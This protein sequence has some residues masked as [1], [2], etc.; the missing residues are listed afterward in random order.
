MSYSHKTTKERFLEKFTVE[1]ISGCWIWIGATSGPNPRP[2]GY[3]RY[4]GSKGET[5]AHRISWILHKV[6]PDHLFLG[7]QTD[8]RRD[9][10][11]KNR[12]RNQYSERMG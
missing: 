2:Y 6:N 8:N 7:T 11:A 12:W 1:P 5:R 4:Q 9:C 10:V 3:L